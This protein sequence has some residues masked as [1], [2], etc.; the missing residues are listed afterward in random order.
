[1]HKL[2]ALAAAA[3]IVAMP[4]PAY[5]CLNG[6]LLVGDEEI[7]ALESAERLLS[8][9]K[10]RAA[11]RVLAAYAHYD[12]MEGDRA[13]AF[14]RR[15]QL[16]AATAQLRM[17]AQHQPIDLERLTDITRALRRLQSDDGLTSPLYKARLAEALALTPGGMGEAKI[18]IE[19]LE[20]NDLIPEPEAWITVAKVRAYVHDVDGMS[21]AQRRC[22]KMAGKRKAVCRGTDFA[23]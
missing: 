3:L 7:R 12:E 4:A 10:H 15:A 5:P 9:G 6:V 17:L 16:V 20:K 13:H 11:L 2:V 14:Q 8:A 23:S 1:M 19:K 22:E 18:L 21:A